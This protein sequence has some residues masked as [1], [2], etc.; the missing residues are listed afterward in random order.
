MLNTYAAKF[1]ANVLRE[2]TIGDEIGRA[3]V[4]NQLE[5]IASGQWMVVPIDA[6]EK[7]TEEARKILATVYVILSRPDPTCE[8]YR[9]AI[10]GSK[11][12]IKQ[13]C[14]WINDYL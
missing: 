14:P 12:Y 11:A 6:S 5:C 3:S 2:S 8:E 9:G 10:E 1:A 13:M 4:I 7:A